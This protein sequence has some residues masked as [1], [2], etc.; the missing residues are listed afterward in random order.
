MIK[1]LLFTLSPPLDRWENTFT[2]TII[3][4]KYKNVNSFAFN[5]YLQQE[6]IKLINHLALFD[7]L[8]FLTTPHLH[9]QTGR[10]LY[11]KLWFLFL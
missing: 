10:F 6:L 9:L 5:D 1:S 3:A 8:F 4:L 2:N 11:E 7:L